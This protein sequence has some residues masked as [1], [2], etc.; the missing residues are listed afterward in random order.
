MNIQSAISECDKTQAILIALLSYENSTSTT[1]D[2]SVIQGLLYA[3]E[4]NLEQASHIIQ[5]KL[6][7]CNDSNTSILEINS[8]ENIHL[9]HAST[10]GDRIRELRK[11]RGMTSDDLA[12]AL[13]VSVACI[14]A[15]EGGFTIP[16]SDKLIPLAKALKCDPM[17]L[18]TGE[19]VETA[20][21]VAE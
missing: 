21:E 17:W 12:N 15:W 7:N 20:E 19:P 3:A 6:S 16:G 8:A 18:L 1:P 5:A 13:N 4:S 11:Q 9:P 2:Q 14:S 10:I